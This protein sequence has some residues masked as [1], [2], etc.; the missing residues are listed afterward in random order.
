MPFIPFANTAQVEAVWSVDGQ[1]V[2]NVLHF[3][4]AA[5]DLSNLTDLADAVNTA[6]RTSILPLIHSG[7]SLLRVIGTLLDVLDGFQFISTASLPAPGTNSGSAM[8]NNV[9]ACISLKSTSRGRSA[10]GRSYIPGIP[11][12]ALIAPSE[13]NATYAAALVTAWTEVLGAGADAGW[14]PVVASRFTGGA[15]RTT[16]VTFPIVTIAMFDNILDSQRRR[17]PGRGA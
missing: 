9:A 11:H 13:I 4:N 6:I 8:P 1:I 2:E 3:D 15:A 16:G 14:S 17:L 10:R 5:P 12:E 7:I